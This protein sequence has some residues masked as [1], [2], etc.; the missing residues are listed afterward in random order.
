MLTAYWKR[1]GEYRC[2]LKSIYEV[3]PMDIYKAT[4]N[5]TEESYI[6]YATVDLKVRKR[7]HKSSTNRGDGCYFHNAIRKY[8]W[9]N[10]R[11]ILLEQGVMDFEILKE[12]EIYWIKEFGTKYPN[13]YNLTDGGGG[14]YGHKHSEETRRK[15]SEVKKGKK[16]GP[17]SEEAKKKM[18]EALK[19]KIPW[20][21][22]K[23]LSEETRRKMSEAKK[24]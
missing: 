7:N 24:K 20:S 14:I 12:L 23:T 18:S 13:G 2:P 9:N 3:E 1:R 4:N 22:G 17:V 11:W 19:G 6:G 16:R 8:G 21:K 15:L 5:I 10:F